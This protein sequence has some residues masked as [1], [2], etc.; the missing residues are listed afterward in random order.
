MGARLAVAGAACP[1]VTFNDDVL[2]PHVD[3]GLDAEDHPVADDGADA[4][5]A[6]VGDVRFFV[7]L[8]A[9]SVAAHFAD[10]GVVAAFAVCL[11]GVG[12]IADA[13]AGDAGLDAHIERLFG[14]AEQVHDFGVDFA[15][16]ECVAHVAHPGV[17]LDHV[18]NADDVS[19]ISGKGEIMED[20][21]DF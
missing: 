16:G 17:F 20:S 18:V 4:P 12:H 14:G 6:V 13:F 3:H 11:N 10:Y 8:V 21:E 5:A 9:Y 1:S 2:G 15:D 19:V 7:H